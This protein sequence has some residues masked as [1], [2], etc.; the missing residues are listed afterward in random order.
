MVTPDYLLGINFP[1]SKL[2]QEDLK[3]QDNR[4]AHRRQFL[5]QI[6]S[7]KDIESAKSLIPYTDPMNP[8]SIFGHWDLGYGET[9]APMTVPY[10]SI[11]AKAISVSMIQYVFDLK[12]VLDTNSPNKA[13]WMKFGSANINGKPFIWSQSQWKGWKLRIVPDR[14]DGDFTLLNMYIR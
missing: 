6:G 11:D 13:F 4:L 2:I 9:P 8:L 3:A 1:A 5:S 10:D 12:G 14:I 7:V